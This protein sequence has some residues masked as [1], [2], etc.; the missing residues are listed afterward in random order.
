MLAA[1]IA[2]ADSRA[3]EVLGRAGVD[4]RELLRRID[5]GCEEYAGGG[6]VAR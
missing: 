1:V 5:A 3:V 6:D 4:A 2:D